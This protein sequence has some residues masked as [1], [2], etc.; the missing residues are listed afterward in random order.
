MDAVVVDGVREFDAE[1]DTYI[2]V[3]E[4]KKD[5]EAW[6]EFLANEIAGSREAFFAEVNATLT[7]IAGR[8]PRQKVA[9]VCHGGVINSYAADVL[10]LP[11]RMF[12]NPDYTSINRFMIASTGERSLRSLNDIGHLRAHPELNLG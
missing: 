8:H 5:K 3:E 9:V 7:E 4:L 11:P 1:H 12:F 2:P 6:K 10:D